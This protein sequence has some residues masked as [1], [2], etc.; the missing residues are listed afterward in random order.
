MHRYQAQAPNVQGKEK[1]NSF[2]RPRP[3]ARMEAAFQDE[4]QHGWT[5]P[6]GGHSPPGVTSGLGTTEQTAGLRPSVQPVGHRDVRLSRSFQPGLLHTCWRRHKKHGV[7][8]SDTSV[9]FQGG[10]SRPHT[11]VPASLPLFR[12]KP[13]VGTSLRHPAVQSRIS[14]TSESLPFQRQFY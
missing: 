13:S 3:N 8:G 14:S 1:V 11:V 7:W 5:F 6:E 10:T 9:P 2:Y 4:G 12:A